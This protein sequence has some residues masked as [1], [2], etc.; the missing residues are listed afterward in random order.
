[1]IAQ[2]G[3]PDMRLPIQYALTYP[4]R[5]PLIGGKKLSL[6]DIG[7]LHFIKPDFKR[8][9][10]LELAYEAGRKGGSMPCVLN[11]ANEQANA[12]FL[13]GK[14]KFLDIERL[15]EEAMR[16]HSHIEN[17][18]LEQLLEI[19]QWARAYVLKRVGE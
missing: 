8:F 18:T 15:V 19:D 2:L 14:I 13:K 5:L 17:P 10:A 12:L 11:A 16:A 4:R 1:M 3:T 7:S 6:S 9:H